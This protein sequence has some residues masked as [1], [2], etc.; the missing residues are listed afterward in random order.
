[1]LGPGQLTEFANA[2]LTNLSLIPPFANAPPDTTGLPRPLPIVLKSN[3]VEL[4]DPTN[5]AAK[6]VTAAGTISVM[7]VPYSPPATAYSIVQKG[8]DEIEI[9][10]TYDQNGV[11]K[12]AVDGGVPQLKGRFSVLRNDVFVPE[13]D[14]KMEA[15][16][17]NADKTVM[18]TLSFTP[19]F[20]HGVAEINT[21]A[22]KDFVNEIV[23][24]IPPK[25]ENPSQQTY[26][27][28]TSANMTNPKPPDGVTWTVSGTIKVR[29]VPDKP[30]TKPD[31][32][33]LP[34]LP[35][36]VKQ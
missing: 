3:L 27:V 26:L 29:L 12:V 13:T 33:P 16:F 10:Y 15:T 32:K 14:V 2:L 17:T 19:K 5:A 34:V 7:L 23:K 11:P 31:E 20:D 8:E 24:L 4:T 36:P 30:K 1:M 25:M 22:L 28:V 9:A 21:Q 18:A 35:L 6:A